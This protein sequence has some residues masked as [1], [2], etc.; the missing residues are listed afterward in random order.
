MKNKNNLL[1]KYL[2]INLATITIS[3]FVLGIT[4]TMFMSA[5]WEEEKRDLLTKNALNF[6]YMVQRNSGIS[7]GRLY[8]DNNFMEGILNVFSTNIDADIFI[9]NEEGEIVLSS[10]SNSNLLVKKK[11]PERILKQALNDRYAGTSTFDGFYDHECYGV[12]VPLTAESNGKILKIGAVF[13][14]SDAK[15][16]TR[17]RTDS[18][19]I[20]SVSAS[21][22]LIISFFASSWIY[23]KMTKPLKE[24]S[25]A[26]RQFGGGNFNKR[27]PVMTND[28]IGQLAISFNSMADSLEISEN[29][30]RNFIANISHEL[31]TPMTT[32]SGFID[33]VL[34][35][36]IAREDRNYYL[37]IVSNE[38]K[39]LSRLIV[40]MLE[41]SRVEGMEYKF[42]KKNFEI[43]KVLVNI[44]SNFKIQIEEKN[45]NLC[46]LNDIGNLFIYSDKDAIYQIIYNL[47]ENA[48]KFTN[49]GG[50]I[51]FRIE[52]D[53]NRI[54]FCIGNT[55]DGIDS[56]Q[57][58]LIFDKFY[59]IDK[60]RSKDKKGMGLG[61][62]IVKTIVR[63]HGGDILARSEKGKY[64]EFSFW[65]PQKT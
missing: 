60:S 37:N 50:S 8:I 19:K 18:T 49:K 15:Q 22:A 58:N 16:M 43:K 52:S 7:N 33:G 26:A 35:G 55:G 6:T 41:L 53:L 11:I 4:L 62:Y 63:L 36:T 56:S 44:I 5:Y 47:V 34:D 10:I 38:I 27:V 12:G 51:Y 29:A 20:F 21:I 23:Y 59:K 65:L 2:L 48:V 54:N 32:I 31:K 40:S 9:V 61:L 39:R 3:F 42:N 1:K 28:E 25:E 57:I 14:I 17:F 45:I 24:M 30:R 46:G 64:C 13:T